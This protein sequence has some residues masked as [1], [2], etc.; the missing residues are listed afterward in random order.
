MAQLAGKVG[1][2]GAE[3]PGAAAPVGC[4]AE[5]DAINQL[6][7][8]GADLDDIGLTDVIRPRTGEVIP[9]CPNCEAMF[10]TFTATA[11]TARTLIPVLICISRSNIAI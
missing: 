5:F 8:L 11:T 7:N 10:E 1:G 3:N 6:L 9:P 2:V 4:C